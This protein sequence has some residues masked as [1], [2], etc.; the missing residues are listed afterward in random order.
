MNSLN[1]NVTFDEVYCPERIETINASV[2]II[3]D[4]LMMPE[5]SNM[6][7]LNN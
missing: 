3:C 1:N 7:S 6:N 2:K 5:S 4:E